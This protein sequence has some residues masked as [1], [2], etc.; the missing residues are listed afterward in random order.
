MLV[1]FEQY[2][3]TLA[4]LQQVRDTLKGTKRKHERVRVILRWIEGLILARI[5]RRADAFKRLFSARNGI[6]RFGF[7]SEY[8]AISAD[9]SPGFTCART[10]RFER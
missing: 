5:G 3:E 10:G 4:C 2:D 7:R 6:E 1:N 8:I 9:I